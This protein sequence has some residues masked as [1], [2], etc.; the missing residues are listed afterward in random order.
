MV[1]E[2]ESFSYESYHSLKALYSALSINTL[3][4]SFQHVYSIPFL[5]F[6]RILTRKC[7]KT[8][9]DFVIGMILYSII[10]MFIVL[11]CQPLNVGA[12]FKVSSSLPQVSFFLA[13]I[14]LIQV[15]IS[16]IAA[17]S[18][19]VL[20]QWLTLGFF[21]SNSDFSKP[22]STFLYF[23]FHYFP[24]MASPFE[25][26]FF[27]C[28]V[29]SNSTSSVINREEAICAMLLCITFSILI[30]HCFIWNLITR[31]SLIISHGMFG[32]WEPPF[33]ALDIS[34]LFFVGAAYPFRVGEKFEYTTIVF[35][36]SILY[37]MVRLYKSQIPKYTSTTANIID[38]KISFDAIILSI[39]G[40]INIWVPKKGYYSFSIMFMAYFVNILAAAFFSGAG[41]KFGTTGISSQDLSIENI[42][43]PHQSISIIRTAVSWSN[44]KV[45]DLN[46]L[47]Y[48]AKWCFSVRVIPD[49]TRLILVE[50]RDLSEIL[51]PNIAFSP[52][53]LIS[54]KFLFFQV[55]IF[56]N[57]LSSDEDPLIQSVHNDINS[58]ISKVNSALGT[59][60][61][62]NDDDHLGIADLWY[63]I[64]DSIKKLRLHYIQFPFSQSIRNQIS[65]F[66]RNIII[67]PLLLDDI[68]QDSMLTLYDT[69]NT[70]Y[71]FVKRPNKKI[72]ISEKNNQLKGVEEHFSLEIF[73]ALNPITRFSRLVFL[74]LITQI[75]IFNSYFSLQ[76]KDLLKSVS[77][78]TAIMNIPLSFSYQTMVNAD[79]SLTLPSVLDIINILSLSEDQATSFRKK[80]PKIE[81][82]ISNDYDSIKL[83]AKLD[84]IELTLPQC[85]NPSIHLLLKANVN[86]QPLSFEYSCY[87]EYLINFVNNTYGMLDQFFLKF[88]HL[89]NLSLPQHFFAL[90]MIYLLIIIIYLFLIFRQKRI[91]KNTM[92]ALKQVTT[93]TNRCEHIQLHAVSWEL[94][95]FLSIFLSFLSSC[96]LIVFFLIPSIRLR[97]KINPMISEYR[98]IYQI[99]SYSFLSYAL[100]V[101]LLVNNSL[102]HMVSI[103]NNLFAQ[104]VN[105][106]IDYIQML[107]LK[108]FKSVQLLKPSGNPLKNLLSEG[109]IDYITLL[110]NTNISAN[111]YRF[112]LSRF[113]LINKIDIVSQNIPGEMFLELLSYIVSVSTSFWPFTLIT[114]ALAVQG[115]L[116]FEKAQRCKLSELKGA[117]TIIKRSII[118]NP[119]M[120]PKIQS[121]ISNSGFN[122]LDDINVPILITTPKQFIIQCNIRF[123]KM[124][125]LRD[126]Q[127]VG[128]PLS[129]ILSI[130]NQMVRKSNGSQE[131]IYTVE[132]LM[133]PNKE[134]CLIFYDITTFKNTEESF[135][136]LK[137]LLCHKLPTLPFKDDRMYIGFQFYKFLDNEKTMYF[138]Y[139]ESQF[140]CIIRIS[141]SKWSYQCSLPLE[142]STGEIMNIVTRIIQTIQELS[143]YISPGIIH[144]FPI[145][146]Y[147]ILAV[148]SGTVIDNSIKFFSSCPK[149]TVYIHQ[150]LTIDT[151]LFPENFQ[152]IRTFP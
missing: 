23:F 128:K 40:L 3:K 37:G 96:S 140:P 63:I 46:F 124:M 151:V 89:F 38:K 74:V 62:T 80:I 51:V 133:G 142:I 98:V 31:Y 82:N 33:S 42:I 94:A 10:D 99:A 21:D 43:N 113:H 83:F 15:T 30:L 105:L 90:P 34:Y 55:G 138:G 20:F 152:I 16:L 32:Y 131:S 49:I 14:D 69:D 39:F 68:P 144:S 48:I 1:R 129:S 150:D 146:P 13:Q 95:S 50:G 81:P 121:I 149:N 27:G 9:V 44:K 4:K 127:V 130:E 54:L 120:L 117:H 85:N 135:L 66:F 25:G 101:E 116:F 73:H 47:Q 76:S 5:Y 17:N 70:V 141:L 103:S 7:Y 18:L 114:V 11:L 77:N 29:L 60:W 147:N 136:Q 139:L 12:S 75:I 45:I 126:Y 26:Y 109:S 134:I 84:S 88:D 72:P 92:N 79:D 65:D 122:Y 2:R 78:Q 115:L 132:T 100:Q 53:E 6:H 71:G 61:T 56:L 143:I 102:S 59:F 19:I 24:V 57:F 125:E 106:T 28:L 104:L 41:S 118:N 123:L 112:L 145:E 119:S 8:S 110:N 91:E 107:S 58:E 52:A 36:I 86:P 148:H 93:V 22:V 97:D 137:S 108:N 67:T 64:E 87:L 111:S 35:V